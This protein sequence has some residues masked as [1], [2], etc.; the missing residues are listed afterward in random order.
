[1]HQVQAGSAVGELAVGAV[2][3]APLFGVFD[4]RVAFPVQQRV[5]RLD[6]PGLASVSRPSVAR[7]CQR[8]TRTWSSPSTAAEW[9]SDQPSTVA[10]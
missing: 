1:V 3:A 8:N 2:D 9:C 7:A 10:A 5:G 4:D 6:R